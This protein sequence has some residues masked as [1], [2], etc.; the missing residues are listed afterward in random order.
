MVDSTVM[1]ASSTPVAVVDALCSLLEAHLNSIF[2][3]LDESSPYLSRAT[4]EVRRQVQE[5]VQTN[6]RQ[7]AELSR[8]IESLGGYPKMAEVSPEEQY[9]AFLS[10]KFLLP[11]L[12]DAEEL[13]IRRYEAALNAVEKSVAVA[14][15]GGGGEVVALLKAHL[16][17]HRQQL[18]VL[19]KAAAD[20]V[21]TGH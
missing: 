5:M 18:S 10:L 7:A 20:I 19:Q 12:A 9:L 4:V 8:A 17:E 3:F 2:R 15:E 16:S 11:K 21:A 6:Q 13:M 1:S 14:V